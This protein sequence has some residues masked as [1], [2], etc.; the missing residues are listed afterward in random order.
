MVYVLTSAFTWLHR[1]RKSSYN[2]KKQTPQMNTVLTVLIFLAQFLIPKAKH[3]TDD[4]TA[5]AQVSD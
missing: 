5:Q 3:K 2:V 1:H 4:I